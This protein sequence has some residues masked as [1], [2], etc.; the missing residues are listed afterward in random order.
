MRL[1]FEK[2]VLLLT[3]PEGCNKYKKND[4]DDEVEGEKE[5][6]EEEFFLVQLLYG[7]DD[8][9]STEVVFHIKRMEK[10]RMP[11]QLFRSH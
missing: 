10:R 3:L 11:Q 7:D 9:E 8:Q 4:D 6:K 1:W 5:E 2:I